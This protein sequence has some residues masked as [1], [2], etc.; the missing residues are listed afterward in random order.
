VTRRIVVVPL[1]VPAW[2]PP[3]VDPHAWRLALAE[4]VVDLLATLAE[5]VP[6]VAVV[7]G[8]RRAAEAV[9]WPTTRVYELPALT[10]DAVFA[11]AAADGY[12]Q[13][14]LLAPD[15]PDLPGMLVGKLLRPLT[16]RPVSVAPALTGGLLGLAARL[17]VPE[18]L[19]ALSLAASVEEV[20]LA[21]P[22]PGQVAQA[23]GWHRLT[24]PSGLHRLDPGLEG[25]DATR[26]LLSAA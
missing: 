13:A 5:V 16:S 14:A 17:P 11:A 24:G 18:W 15:A 22:T 20:R 26:A 1:A 25:W 19:P 12:E 8:D 4:D 9:V 21:A 3:G 6:A 10:S 7:T 2:S 23:T